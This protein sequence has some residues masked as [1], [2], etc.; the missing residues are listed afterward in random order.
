MVQV[1]EQYGKE[2]FVAV[3]PYDFLFQLLFKVTA[4]V[5]VGKT[6]TCRLS[7]QQSPHI[8][9]NNTRMNNID[10]EKYD[11]YVHPA[12]SP[13]SYSPGENGTLVGISKKIEVS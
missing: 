7:L 3:R 11:E 12:N 9:N 1:T 4:I 6:V 10:T 2:I 8:S 13:V 5:Q